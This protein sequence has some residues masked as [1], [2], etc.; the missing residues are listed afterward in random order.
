MDEGPAARSVWIITQGSS[1]P[2][3]RFDLDEAL[4][5]ANSQTR[6]RDFRLRRR[7][8]VWRADH[9]SARVECLGRFPETDT[10]EVWVD[11]LGG[12]YE[13]GRLAA[14]RARG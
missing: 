10:F 5:Y 14:I 3:V 6:R 12:F 1:P 7:P 9:G 13:P 8:V 11:D 4:A 2:V